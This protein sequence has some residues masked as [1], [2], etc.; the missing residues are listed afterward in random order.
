MRVLKLALTSLTALTIT[1]YG[2]AANVDEIVAKAS[3]AAYYQGKD[4][5]AKLSMVI[6]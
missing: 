1:L 5:K 4:G 6:T 2:L 3:E